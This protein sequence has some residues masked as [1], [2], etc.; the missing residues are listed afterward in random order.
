MTLETEDIEVYVAGEE[1]PE[2][3]TMKLLNGVTVFHKLAN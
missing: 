1:T 2:L 3:D